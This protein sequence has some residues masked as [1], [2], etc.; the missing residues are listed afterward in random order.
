MHFLTP[1]AIWMN[2]GQCYG[3]LTAYQRKYDKWQLSVC[4][5]LQRA[6]EL[7]E[8]VILSWTLNQLRECETTAQNLCPTYIKTQE[9]V[10]SGTRICWKWLLVLCYK[11]SSKLMC[12]IVHKPFLIML[13]Q[14]KIMSRSLWPYTDKSMGRMGCKTWV[15]EWSPRFSGETSQILFTPLDFKV[16]LYRMLNDL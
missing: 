11:S 5:F 8:E 3:I 14:Y 2:Y 9:Y 10:F 15:W 12:I 6:D 13:L 4:S 16:C 1:D 7:L